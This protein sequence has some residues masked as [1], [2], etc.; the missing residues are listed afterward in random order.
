M[1]VNLTGSDN[2]LCSLPVPECHHEDEEEEHHVEDGE[3]HYDG[4]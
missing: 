3:L 1:E 2:A 4:G